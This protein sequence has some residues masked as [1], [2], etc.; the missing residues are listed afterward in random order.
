MSTLVGNPEDRFSYDKAQL[1]NMIEKA[2]A[3]LSLVNLSGE[4]FKNNFW[5]MHVLCIFFFSSTYRSGFEKRGS[6]EGDSVPIS[7]PQVFQFE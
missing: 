5:L 3:R 2:H 7:A 1:L 4:N 6:P